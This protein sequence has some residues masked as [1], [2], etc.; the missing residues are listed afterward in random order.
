M[1]SRQSPPPHTAV[2]VVP[3]D[4]A[5]LLHA[6]LLVT[7]KDV[8]WEPRALAKGYHLAE[9]RL[10]QDGAPALL[11]GMPPFA[12]LGF[13]APDAE[14]QLRALRMALAHLTPA[15]RDLLIRGAWHE[16]NG[17]APPDGPGY[18]ETPGSALHTLLNWLT[19]L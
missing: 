12:A 7:L 8:P 14:R 9:W 6:A 11:A 17:T 15:H 16:A 5:N 3:L 18:A 13:A 2:S 1:P 10:L 4:A 19:R